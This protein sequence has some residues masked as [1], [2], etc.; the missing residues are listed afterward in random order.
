MNIPPLNEMFLFTVKKDHDENTSWPQ[1]II[2]VFLMFCAQVAKYELGV[3]PELISF[4]KPYPW[5]SSILI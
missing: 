1:A 5:K 4:E 3:L 2:H